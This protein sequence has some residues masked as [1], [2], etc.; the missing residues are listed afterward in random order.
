MRDELRCA[1]TLMT[2]LPCAT[3]SWAGNH[4]V[5]L[6]EAVKRLISVRMGKIGIG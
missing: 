3:A 4:R 1:A 6:R 2:V 5:I